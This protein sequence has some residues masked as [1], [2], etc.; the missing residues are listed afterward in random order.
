MLKV[1]NTA[2]TIFETFWL[3]EHLTQGNKNID[4]KTPPVSTRK[5]SNQNEWL[6]GELW[7]K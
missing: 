2:E 3:V 4:K 5:T 1:E 6:V 7:T